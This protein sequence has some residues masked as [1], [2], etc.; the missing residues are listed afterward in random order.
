[1]LRGKSVWHI[2]PKQK[3]GGCDFMVDLEHLNFHSLITLQPAGLVA[4]AYSCNQAW[5]K[6]AWHQSAG[7]SY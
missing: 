2:G 3:G 1:M 4:L 5:T 7:M 6:S